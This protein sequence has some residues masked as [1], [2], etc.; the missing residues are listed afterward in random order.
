MHKK[1]EIFRAVYLSQWNRPLMMGK[2]RFR[3]DIPFAQVPNKR[4]VLKGASSFANFSVTVYKEL[5]PEKTT[6]GLIEML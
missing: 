1:R 4:S 6:L 5:S 3:Q 2:P